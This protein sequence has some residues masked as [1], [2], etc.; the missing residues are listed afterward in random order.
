MSATRR[1]LI[2][3]A[4]M[5]A[6][7]I[8]VLDMTIVNVALP[9]IQGS[10]GVNADE[11]S[12][13]LT[14]YLVSSAIFMPLTGFFTA[15]IGQ[16]NYLLLSIAGFTIASALCGA[17]TSLFEIVF[18]RFLQGVFGA[19]LVPLSQAIM[20]SIYPDSER[21]KA[22]AIWGM[23]V[24]VG[25]ILGPTLGGYLTELSNW[26]WIFYVNV[27]I[28]LM[29]LLLTW[30]V[31]PDTLK[32]PRSMDWLGLFYVAL[33]IGAGQ[34]LLDR[35]NQQDWFNALDIKIAALLSVGGLI[36]F[37]LHQ[38][39]H[40]T[41][42]VFDLS[43]FRDRNFTVASLLLAL[44][45]I[46][47][48]GAMVLLPIMLEGVLNY[49]VLTTGLVMAPRGISGMFS[50]IVVG[51]IT[52][53]FDARWLIAIGIILSLLGI[54]GCTHYSENINQWWII[55]PLLLQGFGLSMIFVPLSTVA[56]AT[57]PAEKRA[58]AAGVYSLMRTLGS[59]IGISVTITLFTRHTQ[60]AWN[61]L[62]GFIQP[63]NPAVY[64]YLSALNLLPS[65]PLAASILGQELSNQ[66][67]MV[68]FVSVF[69][70]IMASFIVMLPMVLLLKKAQK[71]ATVVI[72]EE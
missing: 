16:K 17:S 59:S 2:I 3:I 60:I 70:F 66:A 45:G 33:A 38:F 22:M 36:A 71:P 48:F 21:G 37:I 67:Q 64:H 68:A 49:P 72:T 27:P 24:M 8:Q 35:G 65:Q 40:P 31:V 15:R 54:E 19:A 69:Y 12:W 56:F 20:T 43:V 52:N 46:G 28:G 9:H 26:R 13:T 7:L 53:Y 23:G 6:T 1:L 55:W 14:I 18:F 30:Q 39:R 51:K 50:M 41:L 44:M 10:L 29:A 34:Y 61:Y 58:D 4:V 25:P 42:M 32:K 11:I 47:M 5:S 63:Y 57:L 62:N